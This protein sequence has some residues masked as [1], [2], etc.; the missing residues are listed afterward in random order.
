MVP[1]PSLGLHSLRWLLSLKFDIPVCKYDDFIF[2]WIL[3]KR[4]RTNS[5]YEYTINLY[6]LSLPPPPPRVWWW[7]WCIFRGRPFL[8]CPLLQK[9]FT[10]SANYWTGLILLITPW[11]ATC[12]LES[13]SMTSQDAHKELKRA[14]GNFEAQAKYHVIMQQTWHQLHV[15]RLWYKDH[16]LMVAM[17][18]QLI[19]CE[20][21]YSHSSASWIPPH[22]T[23]LGHSFAHATSRKSSLK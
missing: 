22:A 2:R 12:T 23:E 3:Y 17:S 20:I 7:L 19:L 8:P 11:S 5:G 15:A 4:T 10:R 21:P 9:K 6:R 1:N 14:A 16:L 13:N 18:F